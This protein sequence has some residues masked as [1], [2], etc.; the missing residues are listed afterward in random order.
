MK[1]AL[2]CAILVVLI[3]SAVVPLAYETDADGDQYLEVDGLKYRVVDGSAYGISNAV[4]LVN[5]CYPVTG[6]S[7][8]STYTTNTEGENNIFIVPQKITNN[9][10]EYDVVGISG[11][12]FFNAKVTNVS[13]PE[14]LKYID[15]SSFSGSTLTKI[16]IPASVERIGT[17]STEPSAKISSVFADGTKE[18]NLENITFESGSKLKIIGPGAFSY[19]KI[20]NLEIPASVQNIGTTKGYNSY[21]IPSSLYGW[22]DNTKTLSFEDGS[23]YSIDENSVIYNGCVLYC[24]LDKK[25]TSVTIKEGTKTIADGAFYG[26]QLSNIQLPDGL[27]KIGNYAFKYGDF[28]GMPH[29]GDENESGE[30]TRTYLSNI[31]IPGSVKTIGNDFLMGCMNPDGSTKVRIEG[32]TPPTFG[33]NPFMCGLEYVVPN[34]LLEAFTEEEETEV[35]P[36]ESGPKELSFKAQF[37]RSMTLMCIKGTENAYMDAITKNTFYDVSNEDIKSLEKDLSDAF[38]TTVT[39]TFE[40]LCS[41]NIKIESIYTVSFNANGGNGSTNVEIVD[42]SSTI[43]VPTN[44]F[45]REGYKF[46]GWNTSA[47]GNGTAYEA[48]AAI[49]EISDNITLYAQWSANTYTIKFDANNGTGTMADLPMTYGT[50]KNLSANAFTRSGYTFSGWNTAA[51]SSGTS[52]AN[53]ASVNNLASTDGEEII[54]YAQWTRNYV[55]PSGGNSG[56]GGTVTPPKDTT[57]VEKNPD[58]T[59]TETKTENKTNTDGSKTETVTVTDK[60]KDGNITGSSQTETTTSTKKENGSTITSESTTT[61]KKDSEGNVTGSTMSSTTKTES[62]TTTTVVEKEEVKDADD[63]VTS[64]TE[65]TTETVKIEGG[66]VISEK[67]EVTDASGN[68]T[69]TES[70]KAES[71]D[72]VVKTTVESDDST[73][74]VSTVISTSGKIDDKIID[75]AIAQSDAVSGKVSDNDHEKVIQIDTGSDAAKAEV[76]LSPDSLSA[77]AEK[78]AEFKVVCKTGTMQLDKDVI[79]TLTDPKKDV[80]VTMFEPTADDLTEEQVSAK[81]D[82]FGVSM[83]AVVGDDRYHMLGGTVTVTIPYVLPED[84]DSTFGI[85]YIDEQGARTFMDSVYD[86]IMKAFVFQTDHFSLFVVDEVPA[87]VENSDDKTYLYLGIVVGIIIVIAVAAVL[88]KR[89]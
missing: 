28:P 82:R 11:Q 43:T 49:G 73:T 75:M 21:T 70:V 56:S 63:N 62:S 24:A 32:S 66:T 78:G 84:V 45:V 29:E 53:N 50:A 44:T 42:T 4:E 68:V 69:T 83:H 77:I 25:K 86:E 52:Y 18:C 30:E 67:T 26:M 46:T 76:S 8:D 16:T 64:S 23:P 47:D 5:P 87:P 41:G 12:A 7:E 85:F 2:M 38:G 37:S 65:K 51:D 14:G 79:G 57:V 20:Q 81:G 19:T 10:I 71:N 89:H 34:E 3:V 17:P 36:D 88:I 55:P 48:G 59:S 39:V 74:T 58:G 33:T 60:D 72:G 40:T 80:T 6:S 35:N 13:L 54:L 1:K 9:D 27:E 61:T 22:W 15:Q 31:T